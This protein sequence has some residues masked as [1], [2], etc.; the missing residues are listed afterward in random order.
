MISSCSS[1]KLLILLTL[2]AFA[3][4]ACGGGGDGGNTIKPEAEWLVPT[5]W[6]ADGGPGVDGIPAIES[7]TFESAATIGN[8]AA[9]DL[10]IALRSG[11]QVKAYPHD[12]MDYHEIVNDGPANNPFTMSYCPLT[13]SA[14]AWFGKVSA[15]DPSFGVSGFLYNSNLLLYDRE[16]ESLWSQMLQLAVNGPRIREVPA[17]IQ[18]VEMK[19]ETLQAMYPDASVMT[20]ATG[21]SRPYDQYP[22]GN[23]LNDSDLLFQVSRNDTRL[24]RKQRVIG[25]FEGGSAKV[26][27][28]GAFGAL[29]QTINDQFNSQSIVVVGNSALNFAA[30]YSRVLADGTI[31]SFDPI[32]DDLPNVMTDSEGNVWDIF[33]TAVSGPRVG[34]QLDSTRSYT[35]LW[36]AWAAHFTNIEINFN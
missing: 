19:F 6:V 10:V 18:V 1:K 21:H 26:Y 5:Q 28:L 4:T 9:N 31:L 27:Q 33:G 12:I 30:I 11:G 34:T 15:A 13:G 23:Y 17:I 32:Q 29:T 35:A 2:T 22:Y 20:R 25:I 24:A 8:I 3:V 14:M 16:T 7:P 36:F